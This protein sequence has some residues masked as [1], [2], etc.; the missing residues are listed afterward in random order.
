MR[1][2]TQS[3]NF[4]LTLVILL[5]CALVV[6]AQEKRDVKGSRAADEA[7][8]R[9]SVKELEQGWNTKSGAAFARPFSEDAEYVVINGMHIQGRVEIEKGHQRIFD[10]FYKESTLSLN[11]KQIRFLRPDVALVHVS[12]HLRIPQGDTARETEAIITLVMTKDNGVWKIKGFQ[13]TQVTFNQ[14]R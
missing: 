7:A 2:R 6:S 11:V 3:G 13:N 9:E 12:A 14:Q 8:I 4:T 1:R 10:T 5:A